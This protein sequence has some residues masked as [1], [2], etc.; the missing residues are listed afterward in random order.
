MA[1]TGSSFSAAASETGPSRGPVVA[2]LLTFQDADTVAGV[3]TAIRDGLDSHFARADSRIVLVDAG[4]S[5]GTMARARD[6]LAGA[7]FVEASTARSTADLLEVPYHG[8]PGKAR[9]IHAVLTTARDLG[10]RASVVFDGGVSTVSPGWVTSLVSPVI[11]RDLDFVSAF[12]ERHRFEGALTRAIVSPVVRAL[13]GVRLRQPATAEFACSSRFAEHALAENVWT[14]PAAQIGIDLWL[15]TAAASGGFRIGEAEV[16][17]RAH[18]SRGEGG[19]DL[20][21]TIAQI[22]GALFTDVERRAAVWQRPRALAAVEHVAGAATAPAPQPGPVDVERLIETFRLGY[23]ELRDLWASVLP[24]LTILDLKHLVAESGDAF[25]MD[26]QLWARIVYDFALGCRLRVVARDH[27]LRS[28]APL[29]SGW[30]A[31]YILRVRNVSPD[32]VDHRV[33]AIAAA[34]ESQKNYLIARWR[35]PE[36]RRTG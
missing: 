28:L 21:A 17:L 23:R 24:P 1:S 25:V 7:N 26:D 5:D 4:S 31:S 2:G 8:L 18:G 34:F 20:G 12:Y 33:E 9:A 35:W 30:L 11:D 19:L 27:L 15:A 22:V 16:G 10:A 14:H 3:A 32:A 29:Y 13:Y 6:S 36:R